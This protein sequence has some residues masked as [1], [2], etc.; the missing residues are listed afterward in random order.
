MAVKKKSDS[1]KASQASARKDME[2]IQKVL[3]QK[4]REVEF[5][6]KEGVEDVVHEVLFESQIRTPVDTRA[7]YDS[8]YTE[9]IDLGGKVVGEIGY[10]RN[11]EAP[12]PVHVHQIVANHTLGE[13]FFLQKGANAVE[14]DILR[15]LQKSLHSLFK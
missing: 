2:D 1:F 6:T 9:V 7:M 14:K 3:E 11:N 15:V 5:L 13:A 12:Y 8:A 4:L 10:D